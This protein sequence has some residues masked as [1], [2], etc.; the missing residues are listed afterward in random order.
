MTSQLTQ[1]CSAGK[2]LTLISPEC[3]EAQLQ[4]ALSSFGLELFP[5]ENKLLCKIYDGE[6]TCMISFPTFRWRTRTAKK[7]YTAQALMCE[8]NKGYR[9]KAQ[10]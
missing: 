7:N 2:S 9:H 10:P 4:C 8:V 6:I 1:A 5:S 3:I